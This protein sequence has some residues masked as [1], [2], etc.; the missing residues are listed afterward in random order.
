MGV[1]PDELLRLVEVL[2]LE[3]LLGLREGR[4]RQDRLEVVVLHGGLGGVLHANKIIRSEVKII[5][6]AGSKMEEGQVMKRI[7][8]GQVGVIR[9]G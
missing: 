7:E 9:S 8:V 2:A 5:R 6:K 1:V 3:E 4:V